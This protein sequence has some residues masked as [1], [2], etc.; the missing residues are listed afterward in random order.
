MGALGL[1]RATIVSIEKQRR[2]EAAIVLEDHDRMKRLIADSVGEILTAGLTQMEM[3]TLDRLREEHGELMRQLI[4]E[5][6][7]RGW[8]RSGEPSLSNAMEEVL[9]AAQ[10]AVRGYRNPH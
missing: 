9:V 2:I 4:S 10:H 5:A 7:G 6:F 8:V 1:S 3:A